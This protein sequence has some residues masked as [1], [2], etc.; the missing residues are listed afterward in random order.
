MSDAPRAYLDHASGSPL[1]STALAAMRPYLEH[2]FG[3]PGRLHAEGLATRRAIEEAR[4][5]VAGILGARPREV[6]F[7]SGANE[8]LNAAVFGALERARRSG[9]DHAVT[10]AVE[11]SA[12][13]ETLER[14]AATV[15]TVGVDR[16]GRV[17]PE[18][19]AAAVHPGTALVSVQI[20]NQEVGTIQPVAAIV[21]SVR[22]AI[23][24]RGGDALLHLDA[25]TAFGHLAVDFAASG[26]DL[27][28]VGAPGV[29]G[30]TGA[31]ALLVR[32][33]LRIDPL[34]LGGAQERARRAGIEA[35]APIVGFGAAAADLHEGDRF[36]AESVAARRRTDAIVAAAVAVPG[37]VQYGDPRERVPHLV[38][39]GV[40]GIEAEPVLVGLD[41]RGVAAHSGSA[42]SSEMLE[43]SSVLSAMGVDAGHSLRLSVGFSSTDADVAA[44]SHAF[45]VVVEGLRALRTR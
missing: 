17:D 7:T 24:A 41:Q 16:V 11:Q 27:L 30:P 39:I 33:G 43:P 25:T 19:L 45:P 37:T 21:E 32:R 28:S 40:E 9:A 1:R 31:G 14:G 36:D 4:E 38:C 35:V 23:R 2:H 5:Q 10:T 3:D 42:C 18:E 29:G 13:L 8:A 20:A 15:T 34:L 12:I 22:N 26:A 44:F 6:I